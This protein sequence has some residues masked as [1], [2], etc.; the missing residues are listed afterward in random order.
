MNKLYPL[1]FQPILK[2]K[3]WG[4]QKLKDLCHIN[5]NDLKNCGEAWLLSGISDFETKVINGWLRGNNIAELCEVFMGDL[6]GE[7]VFEKYADNFPLLFKLIDAND[8]LSVQVHPN[9][10]LAQQKDELWGKT[11]MWYIMQ[12]DKNAQIISGF[13]EKMDETKLR[14]AIRNKNLPDILHFEN[15]KKDDVVF[16]PSGRVHAICKGIMLAEI[17]QSSD[18]T[19]RLYDW[20]RLNDFGKPRHLHINESF[21]AI[22]YTPVKEYKTK[23]SP[24]EDKTVPVI[25][26]PQFVTNLM[27]ITSPIS[28]DFDELDSFVVYLCTNGEFSLKYDNN[29]YSVGYGE[30]ILIPNAVNKIEIFPKE[31]AAALEVYLP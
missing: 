14:D 19:Y 8:D 29:V 20:D 2:E 10:Q 6:M 21:Q 5:F 18:I 30:V 13:N 3:L 12:A 16:I 27:T 9:D 28:K 7:K 24:K 25:N 1:K 17:Q 26:C 15:V 4:G 23:Y 11:E 22:D 31:K